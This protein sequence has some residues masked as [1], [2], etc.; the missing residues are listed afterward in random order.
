MG[1]GAVRTL[2]TRGA[3][4]LPALFSFL[5][6]LQHTFTGH[7]SGPPAVLGM[8]GAEARNKTEGCTRKVHGGLLTPKHKQRYKIISESDRYCGGSTGG[9]WGRGEGCSAERTRDT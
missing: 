7:S 5:V 2:A 3:V 8:E 6:F 9:G 4:P 1:S